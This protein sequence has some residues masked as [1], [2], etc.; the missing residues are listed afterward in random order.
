MDEEDEFSIENG[1]LPAPFSFLEQYAKIEEANDGT[2]RVSGLIIVENESDGIDDQLILKEV[3]VYLIKKY[4]VAVD[5][6]ALE[7]PQELF[8]FD[9]SNV[10]FTLPV[11]TEVRQASSQKIVV[12]KCD[13]GRSDKVCRD[14]F[15]FLDSHEDELFK[16]NSYAGELIEKIANLNEEEKNLVRNTINRK[17]VSVHRIYLDYFR[18]M[19]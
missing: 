16:V 18:N 8:M 12:S 2:K 1:Y 17:L 13:Q 19:N 11:S 3:L 14:F 15:N 10:Q 7:N 6:A 9:G 5:P 4:N